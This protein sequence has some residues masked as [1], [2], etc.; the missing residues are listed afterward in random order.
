[1]SNVKAKI[2]VLQDGPYEVQ[3]KLPLAKLTIGTNAKGESLEWQTGA[4]IP[5]PENAH[6]CR[7]GR[8]GNKPFCDGSHTKARF[9]GTETASREP[10]LDVAEVI[11]GPTLRLTDAESLCAFAR[12]CDP[13]GRVWNLVGQSDE[14]RAKLL[15][16]HEA[17]ACPGGRLVAWEKSTGKAHEPKLHPQLGLIEDPA[18][19]CSGGIAVW[20]GVEVVGADG[21]GYEVR[22]RQTLCRCGESSNKPFCD[23]THASMKFQ[24][25]L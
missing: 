7:C 12:F 24:D 3:G 17:G 1:M 2:V 19:G 21:Q 20:G 4:P 8:S 18:Q 13:A 5:T 10:Y 25:N 22:N 9:D 15:T 11:D 16:E 6:L 23:G 14:P